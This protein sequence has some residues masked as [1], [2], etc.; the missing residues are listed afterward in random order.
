MEKQKKREVI[1]HPVLLFAVHGL[2]SSRERE[3]E[4]RRNLKEEDGSLEP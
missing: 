2:R 4:I 3:R 1:Y